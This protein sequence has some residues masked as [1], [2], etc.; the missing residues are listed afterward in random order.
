MNGSKSASVLLLKIKQSLQDH[1]ETSD[2]LLTPPLVPP[3]NP[4]GLV[5]RANKPYWSL[6][7]DELSRVVLELHHNSGEVGADWQILSAYRTLWD[8]QPSFTCTAKKVEGVGELKPIVK[9]QEEHAN[10]TLGF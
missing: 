4:M 10:S 8:V 9:G 5:A 1:G 7:K 2:S 6:P 3:S